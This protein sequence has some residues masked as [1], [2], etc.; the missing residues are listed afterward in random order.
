MPGKESER[1]KEGERG[2]RG[3]V[4]CRMRMYFWGC[5]GGWWWR[6]EGGG[7]WVVCRH[8]T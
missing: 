2:E 3:G 4:G 7:G 1:E 5:V 8:H 6:G